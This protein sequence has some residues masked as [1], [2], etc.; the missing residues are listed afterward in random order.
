MVKIIILVLISFSSYAQVCEDPTM[1]SKTAGEK[2][3]VCYDDK[4]ETFI[5]PPCL[6]ACGAKKFLDST[7]DLTTKE[8]KGG[9][10]AHSVSCTKLKGKLFLYRDEKGNEYA[11]CEASDGSAIGASALK[12]KVD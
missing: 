6:G 10:D 7:V 12:Y 9:K 2:V 1:L 3:K 5:T 11:M 4:L 8:L